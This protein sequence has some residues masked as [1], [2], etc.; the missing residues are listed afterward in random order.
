MGLLYFRYIL[1]LGPNKFVIPINYCFKSTNS[2][3]KEKKRNKIAL[4]GISIR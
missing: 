2:K 1:Y 3:I 4:Y